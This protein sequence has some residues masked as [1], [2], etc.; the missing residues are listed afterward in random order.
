MYNFDVRISGTIIRRHR[1]ARPP[2]CDDT[3]YTVEDFNVGRELVFYGKTFKITDLD[4]FTRN[5]LTKL[6]VRLQNPSSVP[7]DPYMTH[8]KA[9]SILQI[10]SLISN[11]SV[12]L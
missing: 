9:V 2:P 3:F 11:L 6:G 12:S 7:N 5:F 8:R 4:P 1:I 10:P